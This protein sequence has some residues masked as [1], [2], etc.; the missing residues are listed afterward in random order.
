M[1]IETSSTVFPA[2]FDKVV[3]RAFCSSVSQ[4]DFIL[5]QSHLGSEQMCNRFYENYQCY[6]IADNYT[7]LEIT[8]NNWKVLAHRYVTL[9]SNLSVASFFVI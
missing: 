7:V 1:H 3:T 4:T 8:V 6:V 9:Q 2:A 5:K